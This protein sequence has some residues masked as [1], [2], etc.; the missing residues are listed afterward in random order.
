MR[1]EKSVLKNVVALKSVRK[2]AGKEKVRIVNVRNVIV[3]NQVIVK[4]K[5]SEVPCI[6][7]GTI[8]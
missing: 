3:R 8:P 6:V 7:H 5:K 2:T 4:N 1:V